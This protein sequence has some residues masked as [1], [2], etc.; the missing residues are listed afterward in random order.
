MGRFYSLSAEIARYMYL[1]LPPLDLFYH[2]WNLNYFERILRFPLD[3]PLRKQ[4]SDN[5]YFTK[6]ALVSAQTLNYDTKYWPRVLAATHRKPEIPRFKRLIVF[7]ELKKNLP[8]ETCIDRMSK[9][10]QKNPTAV[11][12]SSDGSLQKNGR[13]G[14]GFCIE[15]PGDPAP[16]L[17]PFAIAPTGDIFDAEAYAL[18]KLALRIALIHGPEK[19]MF[20]VDNKGV[21]EALFSA[22]PSDT[23]IIECI[24]ILNQLASHTVTV[25]WVPS[26]RGITGNERADKQAEIGALRSGTAADYFPSQKHSKNVL[27]HALA[28][29]FKETWRRSTKGAHLKKLLLNNLPPN[30]RP[31]YVNKK[32]RSL[33]SKIHT[34]GQGPWRTN[35]GHSP[36]ISCQNAGLG[37]R[38]ETLLHFFDCRSNPTKITARAKLV[39]FLSH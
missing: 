14:G 4:V 36:C 22:K 37:I 24:K 31:F 13:I 23:K 32:T 17:K 12:G 3:N 16:I 34:G 10:R 29:A 7:P 30:I 8:K 6:K 27:K 9:L 19:I 1:N 39:R 20:F 33:W 18:H 25:S 38:D 2:Y 26:H 21:V 11:W 35:L 15:V 5:S 28:K